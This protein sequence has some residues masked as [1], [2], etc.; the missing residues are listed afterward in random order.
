M[1]GMIV[2]G[3]S[4]WKL[5]CSGKGFG[6]LLLVRC[7]FR[8]LRLYHRHL[9]KLQLLLKLL[10]TCDSDYNFEPVSTE[11]EYLSRFDSFLRDWERWLIKQVNASGQIT[12]IMEPTMQ[13]RYREYN[14]PKAL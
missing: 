6:S 11:L 3:P 1:S 9:A 13:L 12:D 2:N 14:K 5:A 4:K 10:E 8:G 7:G